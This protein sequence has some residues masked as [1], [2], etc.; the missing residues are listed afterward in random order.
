MNDF[1]QYLRHESPFRESV[2]RERA[3]SIQEGMISSLT[4]RATLANDAN[5][6]KLLDEARKLQSFVA[7]YGWYQRFMVRNRFA[8]R[9]GAGSA[10]HFDKDLVDNARHEMRKDVAH[11]PLSCIMNTDEVAVL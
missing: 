4:E 11:F 3:L 6:Q 5:V 9:K 1:I 2:V 8:S 10:K 7:S